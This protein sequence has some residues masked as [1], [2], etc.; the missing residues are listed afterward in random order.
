M[1]NHCQVTAGGRVYNLKERKTSTGKS[2]AQFTLTVFK[3]QG[4][5]KDDKPIFIDC[6]AYGTK[7]EVILKHVQD[8]TQLFIVGELD[9]YKNKEGR[10]IQNL[11]V[12]EFHFTDRKSA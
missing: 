6:V 9:Q 2:I 4:E 8:K 1:L 11:V 3:K 12:N 10:T 5:G 7:A